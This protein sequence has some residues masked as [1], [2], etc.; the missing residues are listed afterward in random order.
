VALTASKFLRWRASGERHAWLGRLAER[1]ATLALAGA[2]GLA[3]SGLSATVALANVE[4]RGAL[5]IALGRAAIVAVPVAVGVYAMSRGDEASFGRRLVLVGLASSLT[6]LSESHHALLHSV[7]RI[8]AWCVQLA[9]FWLLLSF[10]SGRLSSRVDR[11]LILALAGLVAVLFLPSALLVDRFPTPSPWASCEASCPPNAFQVVDSE[12]A[13]LATVIVPAREIVAA[14]LGIA[15]MA[16]LAQRVRGA[17]EL[18]R[19]ALEPVLPVAIGG[20][21]M[22]VLYFVARRT[23]LGSSLVSVIGWAVALT[24]PG[25][26][27]AFLIGI[28]RWQVY[29]GAAL[30]ELGQEIRRPLRPT[31]LRLALSRALRDPSLDLVYPSLDVPGEWVDA[32]G[33]QV[34]APLDPHDVITEIHRGDRVAA[35]LVHDRTLLEHSDFLEAVGT[36][37]LIALDNR[38]LSDQVNFSLR[39]LRVS[40]ARLAAAAD[41]ERRKIERDLHDGAQQRLVALRMRLGAT[42]DLFD[43]A[44]EQAKRQVHEVGEQIEATLEEIRALARGVYPPLLA[45][46]G[47]EEALRAAALRLPVAASLRSR[48]LG[49]YSQATESAVYFCCIEA[50]QNASK[51][52]RTASRI[53]ITLGQTDVLRFSVRDDGFG[54]D[55]ESVAWGAGLTNMRDRVAAVGG[56]LE[57]LS[58]PGRGTLVRGDV[59]AT[60]A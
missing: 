44:P 57:I 20:L 25:M 58:A 54:F 26:A 7:G 53:E 38:R 36:F 12:A 22:F 14:L 43:V 8:A 60:T 4:H 49:R 2:L 45:E 33:Q 55:I 30:Q 9:L 56:K 1:P 31:Q 52:A 6:T 46:R 13:F 23:S 35:G 10:P 48:G 27:L 32:G 47:L 3:L 41:E 19:R 21:A 11:G 42:E 34:K 40:R 18:M 39:E 16:R 37:A 5:A 28:L 50:M 29:V 51:H 24:L 17:S 15:L 59:P